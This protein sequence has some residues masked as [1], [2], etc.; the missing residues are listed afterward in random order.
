MALHKSP[1]VPS[2]IAAGWAV[3]TR[4]AVAS[5]GGSSL[6]VPLKVR[7]LDV[8]AKVEQARSLTLGQIR[9]LPAIIMPGPLLFHWLKQS[10]CHTYQVW[11]KRFIP[12]YQKGRRAM[13]QTRSNF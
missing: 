2:E 7:L 8:W 5:V 10:S 1:S 3:I 12:A 11:Y 9:N 4:G 6:L 13:S